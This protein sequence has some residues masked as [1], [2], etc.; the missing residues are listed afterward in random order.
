[1][2]AAIGQDAAGQGALALWAEE[3]IDAAA[4]THPR[5]IADR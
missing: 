2:V 4:V 5:R 3:G 1:M